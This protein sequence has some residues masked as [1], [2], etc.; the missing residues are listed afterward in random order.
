MRVWRNNNDKE[1]GI[2]DGEDDDLKRVTSR[3]R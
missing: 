3:T 1:N 2:D